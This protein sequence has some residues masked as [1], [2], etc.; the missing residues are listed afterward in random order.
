SSRLPLLPPR[1]PS[2]PI[3]TKWG[4][5]R[6]NRHHRAGATVS[7]SPPRPLLPRSRALAAGMAHLG[8]LSLRSRYLGRVP[9][10]LK[11]DFVESM[12]ALANRD[13]QPRGFTGGTRRVLAR[14][15][16][17]GNTDRLANSMEVDV[18]R[19]HAAQEV[20]VV[21]VD[22]PRLAPQVVVA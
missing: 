2:P 20:E 17:A 3:L 9:E 22:Q 12:D 6:G 18:E 19:F 5:S 10:D 16:V 1:P 8:L 15:R 13:A 14:D 4:A 7:A 11:V 21:Q